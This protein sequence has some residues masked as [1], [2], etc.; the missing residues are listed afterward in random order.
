V[1]QDKGRGDLGRDAMYVTITS[2]FFLEDQMT[3]LNQESNRVGK[4]LAVR[5]ISRG[6]DIVIFLALL[7][8]F[9]QEWFVAAFAVSAIF[10]Y[11]T[12]FVGQKFWTFRNQDFGRQSLLREFVI[13]LAIRSGNLAAAAG[14]FGLMYGILKF[15]WLTSSIA[16][17][18]FF[19]T[20]VF[21]LYRWLFVGSIKDLLH[22]LKR[23]FS[24]SA[25]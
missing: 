21:G 10:N 23:V 22:M 19:W 4:Y 11:V 24:R 2:L 13:Y 15:S 3:D 14:F 7:W 1:F 8:W 17:V 9:G 5:V 12:D 6:G 18:V 20:I 25:S 16:T